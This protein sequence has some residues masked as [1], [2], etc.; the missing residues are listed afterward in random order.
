VVI[1][2]FLALPLFVLSHGY[3]PP[4]DALRH[5]AKAVSGK[6]WGEILVMRPE[7]T[8]DHNPGWHS[9][10]GALH[11]VLGWDT[12]SL[13]RFSVILMFLVFTSAPLFFVERPE[14]WLGSLT[15]LLMV[16]PY[17]AERAFV[18][19]PL[20]VTSAVMMIVFSLWIRSNVARMEWKIALSILLIALSVWVHGSWYVLFLI[21]VAFFLARAWREGLILAICWLAGSVL[22]ALATGAPQEFL[23]QTILIPLLA[24]GQD[25]PVDSLVGEFQPLP[26][27]AGFPALILLVVVCA[28]RKWMGRP[29]NGLVRDPVLWMVG[30][31]LVLGFWVVRFWLDWGLPALALWLALQLQE[32]LGSKLPVRSGRRLV[33]GGVIAGVLLVT[34]GSDRNDRWSGSG[35]FACL[36]ANR[37][38][39]REWLPQPDGILYAVELSV[40]YQTFFCNPNGNWRYILGF[41]P[42]LMRPEDLAVY[43]ELW[44]SRNALRACAPWVER[45]TPRDRLVLHSG[46]GIRPAL[47]RLEWHYAL[48]NTWVGRPPRPLPPNPVA[49]PG[50]NL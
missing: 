50:P 35:T 33:V 17:F 3:L 8:I 43:Q 15:L 7:I 37:P 12:R 6:S 36:N 23:S 32:L 14:A 41:E 9:I 47:N 45:M 31:G 40:F 29:L 25:A 26:W 18:G 21:P 5:A 10:L 22:G 44:R 4:D 1:L 49:P 30:L 13:V 38:E 34:V 27:N 24:L 20:F 42:S 19:R 39:D 16:F 46:P 11:R 2:S 48:E 28:G